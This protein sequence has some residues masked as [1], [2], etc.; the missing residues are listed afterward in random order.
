MT[1]CRVCGSP[2]LSHLG[3]VEYLEGYRAQVH[4]CAECGCRLTPHDSAVHQRFHREPALSYYQNYP[5]VAARC[6]E[7]FA[8]GDRDGLRRQLSV[9]AK[10]RFIIEQLAAIPVSANILEIGCSRG[11]LTSLFVLEHRRILGVDVSADAIDAAREAFGPHFA[12]AGDAEIDA[13]S[14]YDVIYHVGL[15]GCVADPIG[16]TRGLLRQLR[17]GGLLLFNA[18][19]RAALRWAD[20]LW[21][22]SAP[23]PDLVTLFPERFWTQFFGGQA[24]VRV[25]VATVSATE[26]MSIAARQAFGV[27]WQPPDP[28]PFSVR[29][30]HWSQPGGMRV[31]TARAVAKAATLVGAA[32][33]AVPRPA[34]FGMFVTLSP[35]PS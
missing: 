2:R 10:N 28:Q 24:D 25:E 12:T 35:R 7:L 30:H 8:A 5:A 22:D 18:P 3:A 6:R 21:I 9:E 20:Q 4:D 13:R 16:F 29:G 27:K 31:L 23:P 17:P 14:P 26:S 34:E 1:S 33:L 19:N 15:I 32:T 11:Y